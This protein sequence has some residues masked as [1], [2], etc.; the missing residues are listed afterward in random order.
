[1]TET[2]EEAL[3]EHF[4][5]N[6]FRAHQKEIIESLLAGKDTVAILPTGA[7]KSICYQLPARMLAGT[8]FVVSPLISLMQDQVVQLAKNGYP[9]LFIN[10]SV[11]Y[12][13]LVDAL[14]TMHEQKLVY[15]AP[16]RFS[17]ASF[18]ERL[19]AIKISFFVVDEA[20]CISQ[21]GHVFRPEYRKLSQLKTL[22][23]ETPIIALTATATQEVQKDI[24]E[25]LVMKAPTTIKGSFDRPNLS[26]RILAKK[27][28]YRQ[29]KELL[30]A[31]KQLPGII[32]ASKRKTVDALYE[33][34]REDTFE[35]GRYH[36]GMSDSERSLAHMN[37]LHDR[38]SIMVA[39]VAF[40]MGIHKPNIRYIIHH[41]MPQTMEQY[42]QEI[43]RAGRDGLPA[44]CIM[45]FSSE[46]L[47]IIRFFISQQE[48]PLVLQALEKKMW[49]M[50]RFCGSPQCRRV[51]LLSYFGEKYHANNCQ[52]CDNCLGAVSTID[53]T[54]IAQKI[55]S[56]IG[57][58]NQNFG[59]K[60]VIDVLRGANTQ[61]IRRHRHEMLSTYGLM[62]EYSEADLRYYID[63]LLQQEYITKSR[64]EYPLLQWTDRTKAVLQGH[65]K[66][67]FKVH[68]VPQEKPQKKE[69]P[70][71][72]TN[73]FAILKQARTERARQEN[74]PP[75]VV[76]NDR[77]LIEM[78][79]HFPTTNDAF[80]QING[81]GPAKL[82][83]YGPEFLQLIQEYTSHSG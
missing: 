68:T 54:L 11:Q 62:R 23:P 6:C 63:C 21:W 57:R 19:K 45:L 76:F 35:V 42:Y 28:P 32:Y 48:D 77:S 5:Y 15:V 22:F 12:Q 18:I 65:E 81:V 44:D 24:Q 10:S 43:G 73:L 31:R 79:T 70:P 2:L 1:M 58:V 60:H 36:A 66:V 14:D 7:G 49:K 75:Y 74:V 29:I 40:G 80:L 34:L 78:A 82:V 59:T 3:K 4:G 27:D 50:Y 41:D 8:A 17:D 46:D 16:E 39:T 9:A 64:G 52:G 56:C 61:A 72:D 20:H 30:D 53:G 83:K 26:L 71:H 55:L 25:Q 47:E 38:V 13:E 67:Q 33:Q 51:D 69:A 37:F